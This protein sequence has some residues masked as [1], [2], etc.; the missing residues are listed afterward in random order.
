MIVHLVCEAD[1]DDVAIDLVAFRQPSPDLWSV[2]GDVDERWRHLPFFMRMTWA[3]RRGDASMEFPIS[4]DEY[5]QNQMKRRQS[6]ARI[7]S[8]IGFGHVLRHS[9]QVIPIDSLPLQYDPTK[10]RLVVHT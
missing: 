6:E 3:V 8:L 10:L 7:G 4:G 5:L 1:Q 2:V 9:R